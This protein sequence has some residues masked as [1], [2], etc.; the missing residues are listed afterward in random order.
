MKIVLSICVI[1]LSHRPIVFPQ[2]L[3]EKIYTKTNSHQKP[4]FGMLMEISLPNCLNEKFSFYVI[5][6]HCS[7]LESLYR[8][9][10]RSGIHPQDI[11]FANKHTKKVMSLLQ[12][13]TLRSCHISLRWDIPQKK[14]GKCSMHTLVE[15][16][17]HL[18]SLC[19]SFRKYKCRTIQSEMTAS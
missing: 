2:L 15:I 13:T 18:K 12:L 6:Y 10:K 16:I 9:F 5:V 7:Y 19:S 8:V 1:L 11:L 4:V 3:R 17:P 14:S